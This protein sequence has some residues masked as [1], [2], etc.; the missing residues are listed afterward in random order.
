MN[1]V[2]T[3]ANG[4]LGRE[5][6]RL[7][8]SADFDVYP[9]DRQQMDIA[10]ENRVEQVFSRLRPS[11]VINAA[12]YTHVDQA[13]DE[14]ARAYA[15]NTKGP[16]YLARYCAANGHVLIHISTDYVFDGQID[17]PYRESDPVAPLGVYGRSKAQGE[18]AIRSEMPNHLIVRTSW[19]YGVYRHNFV[20]TMLKLAAEKT[21]LQVVADQLGSPT[22]AAD[23]AEALMIITHKICTHEKFEW[24][25]Y[26]YCGAGI[27]SWHGLAQT[28]IDL[29]ASYVDLRTR[30]I[31]P[32][33]TAEWPT[34]APRPLYTALDCSRLK[35]NFGI[36]PQPWQHSL[37]LTIDRMFTGH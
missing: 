5:L 8:T 37:K 22:S 4:Q 28:A 2:I 30:Q 26:H 36:D 10:D 23:L 20:K 17:R 31:E 25:T 9:L 34:R 35:V 15:V 7:G 18:M 1:V 24:G 27:T 19:L 21:A 33:T 13:E 29:A 12:A 16:A 11:V 32:I 3:G 14:P 6:V